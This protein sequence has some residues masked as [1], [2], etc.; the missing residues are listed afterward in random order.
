MQTPEFAENIRELLALE[1]GRRVA[2]MC[3]ESVPWRCHRSLIADALTVR[4][5]HVQEIIGDADCRAHA[6]TAFAKVDGTTITYPAE[7]A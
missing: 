1:G 7:S 3:A 6:L 4:G 2:V 5:I